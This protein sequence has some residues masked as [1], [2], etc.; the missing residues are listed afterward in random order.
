MTYVLT[1]IAGF[2]LGYLV[3]GFIDMFTDRRIEEDDEEYIQITDKG[4][5]WLKDNDTDTESID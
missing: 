4:L 1:F 3:E 2:A 5:Q